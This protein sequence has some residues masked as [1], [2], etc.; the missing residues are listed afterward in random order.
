MSHMGCLLAGGMARAQLTQHALPCTTMLAP[1]THAPMHPSASMHAPPC[2][3]I[4]HQ[5]LRVVRVAGRLAEK[6]PVEGSRIRGVMVAG[7]AGGGAAGGG[8][9]AP[10]L[11][12]HPDDLPALTKLH[13]GRVTQRQ[14]GTGG[15]GGGGLGGEAVLE[16]GVKEN[17]VAMWT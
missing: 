7:G 5:P 10:Q 1:R 6:P 4:Q 11:L 17:V 3:Q 15:G 8:A 9:A 2:M 14:V 16:S 13:R 12:L